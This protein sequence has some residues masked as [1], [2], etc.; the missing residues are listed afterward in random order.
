MFANGLSL[1]KDNIAQKMQCNLGYRPIHTDILALNLYPQSQ[2]LTTLGQKAFKKNIFGKG[3]NA[4]DQHFLL[5][6]SHFLPFPKRISTFQSHSFVSSANAFNL[7]QSKILSFG[8]EFRQS[9]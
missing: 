2:L 4:D 8:K 1:R 9:T 7:D 5:F 3:E 6:P